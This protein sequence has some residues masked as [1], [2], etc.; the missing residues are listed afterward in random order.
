MC[1]GQAPTVGRYA[2]SFVKLDVIKPGTDSTLV[3]DEETAHSFFKASSGLFDILHE[4]LTM[5]YTADGK[6]PSEKILIPPSL[7]TTVIALEE[8]L[9]EWEK[10]LPSHL[11]VPADEQN[12]V[13]SLRLY[14]A[15][16]LKQRK[17]AK[18][19]PESLMAT[20]WWMNVLYAYTAAT[21]IA[22]AMLDIELHNKHESPSLNDSMQDVFT[23]LTDY[24]S[25]HPIA[26]RCISTLTSIIQPRN[27]PAPDR[28]GAVTSVEQPDQPPRPFLQTEAA[29][30]GNHEMDFGDGIDFTID[31][32]HNP[33]FDFLTDQWLA[34][35]Q[36]DS[37]DF[38]GVQSLY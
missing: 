36:L 38:P 16:F 4:I 20:P 11:K 1:L 29:H 21:A 17:Q 12:S 25:Q 3:S 8:K 5:I 35:P 28:P 37:F 15:H 23:L 33:M 27:P 32:R 14:P 2:T 31:D 9:D 22:A 34:Q 19:S 13:N 26:R 24:S 6:D 18:A 7:P 30:E 10:D